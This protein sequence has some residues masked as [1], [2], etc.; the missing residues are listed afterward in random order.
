MPVHRLDGNTKNKHESSCTQAQSFPAG[1]VTS[2][3]LP[4]PTFAP[5]NQTERA[6]NQQIRTL[7]AVNAQTKPFARLWMFICRLESED[8]E[9]ERWRRLSAGLTP[10]AGR[11][12]CGEGRLLVDWGE[13]PPR[14]RPG[15]CRV[16]TVLYS[17]SD[18]WE[19]WFRKSI[20]GDVLG[21]GRRCG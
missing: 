2:S 5:P 7:Y 1:L 13:G 16:F 15:D 19:G 18:R 4:K 6:K 14:K 9:L 12:V 3:H 20:V 8:R 11:L 21:N 17:S 10:P